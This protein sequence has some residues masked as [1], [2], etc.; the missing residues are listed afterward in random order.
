VACRRR[1]GLAVGH[2]FGS[3]PLSSNTGDP[4]GARR[5][6]APRRRVRPLRSGAPRASAP[7]ADAND[8]GWTRRA[9]LEDFNLQ[10]RRYA[11]VAIGEERSEA[12]V[13][14]SRPASVSTQVV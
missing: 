9:A 5:T 3:S 4:I 8:A 11:P 1:I 14:L 6:S 10:K 7:R 12:G 13:L 2:R